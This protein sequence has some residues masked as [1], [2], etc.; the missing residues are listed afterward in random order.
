MF[1]ILVFTW[2]YFL[3]TNQ[4]CY[5]FH[6]THMKYVSFIMWTHN[7]SLKNLI[8]V[9]IQKN[10]FVKD[11]K[12]YNQ[13]HPNVLAKTTWRYHLVISLSIILIFSLLPHRTLQTSQLYYRWQRGMQWMWWEQLH[14]Q[15]IQ[16]QQGMQTYVKITIYTV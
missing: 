11:K 2:L 7:A 12:V 5:D 13:C 14:L 16:Q 8:P 3:K 1:L 10:I 9:M 15:V 4:F 6:C